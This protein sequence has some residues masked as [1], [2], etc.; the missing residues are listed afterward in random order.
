MI[1]IFFGLLLAVLP[2]LYTSSHS[3]LMVVSIYAGLAHILAFAWGL[4]FLTVFVRR[5]R[6]AEWRQAKR[7]QKQYNNT[8]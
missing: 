7:V 3:H 6:I 1:L 5:H 4:F 2:L 8:K